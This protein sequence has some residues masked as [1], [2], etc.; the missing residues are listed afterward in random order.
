MHH[1]RLCSTNSQ[2]GTKLI[3][4]IDSVQQKTHRNK[5]VSAADES[6]STEVDVIPPAASRAEAKNKILIVTDDMMLKSLQHGA[7][8]G[9]GKD[10]M[11]CYDCGDND[12]MVIGSEKFR[13]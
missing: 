13:R 9:V 2:H 7:L 1:V 10:E 12:N 6:N 5:E 3:V 4:I 11:Q 8:G